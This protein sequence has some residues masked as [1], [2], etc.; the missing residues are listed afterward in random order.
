MAKRKIN[1]NFQL[2]VRRYIEFMH[3]EEKSVSHK[4]NNLINNLSK[5][6]KVKIFY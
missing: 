1:G 2:K 5:S 6:L 4:G 3:E